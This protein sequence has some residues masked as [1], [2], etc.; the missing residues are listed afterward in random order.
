ML[1]LASALLWLLPAA[2]FA[3][4]NPATIIELYVTESDYSTPVAGVTVTYTTPSLSGQSFTGV[5]DGA[6][7]VR[8]DRGGFPFP[9]ETGTLA[10]PAFGGFPGK[11]EDVF[12]DGNSTYPDSVDWVFSYLLA[13]DEPSSDLT[14]TILNGQGAPIP[15]VQVDISGQTSAHI[16]FGYTNAAGKI[17]FSGLEDEDFEVTVN[18]D[19]FAE[20]L[21]A[22]PTQTYVV[23]VYTA[24][25][26]GAV[27]E[28]LTLGS[29]TYQLEVKVVK[30]NSDGTLSTTPVPDVDV[31]AWELIPPEGSSGSEFP[32]WGYGKT[33]S[34]GL[35][36]M[37]MKEFTSNKI[38]I[39]VYKDGYS[40][41]NKE[42]RLSTTGTKTTVVIGIRQTDSTINYTLKKGSATGQTYVVPDNKYADVGCNT[43]DYQSGASSYYYYSPV[44]PGYSSGSISVT[45]GY[46]YE[47]RAWIEGVGYS[48]V[49]TFVNSGQT[50]NLTF[51]IHIP[52]AKLTVEFRD[53]VTGELVTGVPIDLSLWTDR[54]DAE[55]RG[56]TFIEH[57]VWDQVDVG[58]KTF[59]VIAGQRYF[60]YAHLGS[61]FPADQNPRVVLGD[62]GKEYIIPFNIDPIDIKTGSN[63]K[64][65]I[66]L[67]SADA[68]IRVK[69]LDQNGNPVKPSDEFDPT[70]S[71]W[72]NAFSPGLLGEESE[73]PKETEVPIVPAESFPSEFWTDASFND[74]AALFNRPEH[75]TKITTDATNVE[76]ISNASIQ[77]TGSTGQFGYLASYDSSYGRGQKTGGDYLRVHDFDLATQYQIDVDNR[78]LLRTAY[79]RFEDEQIE[80]GYS[81]DDFEVSVGSHHKLSPSSTVLTRFEVF[82]RS[83]D[84]FENGIIENI[85]QA[86]VF[87]SERFP[88]DP[89]TLIL[90]QRTDEDS[91]N[92]RGNVQYILD[93]EYFDIV[94][95]AQYLS[96][97]EDAHEKSN[98]IK[99]IPD[100]TSD[101]PYAR[102]TSANPSLDSYSTYLYTTIDPDP[103]F[104]FQ[105]GLSYTGIELPAYDV[106]A[107]FADGKRSD[108]K[109][110]PKIGLSLYPTEDT[111]VR[112]AYFQTLGVSTVSDIGTLEPTLVGSFNQVYGDLPGGS[113]ENFGVGIDHKIPG[114]F[115]AGAEYVY[116]D[117]ARDG[118]YISESETL[119]FDSLLETSKTSIDIVGE[120]EREH[121]IRTYLYGVLS[122]SYTA[123]L[124]YLRDDLRSVDLEQDN[125]TDRIAAQINYFSPQRWFAFG[126]TSWYNQQLEN[127]AVFDD[128]SEDFWIL[129]VGTGYRIP[130]RHGM[131]QLALVNVLDQSFRYSDRDRFVAPPQGIGFLLQGS[132][133]F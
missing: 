105:L 66:E 21:P 9:E 121:L 37:G 58:T 123:T 89:A 25:A 114:K 79:T 129:D 125:V 93:Q 72:V 120:V 34:E 28:S 45:G 49:K 94:A 78:V 130:E 81:R 75:R 10:I 107:P 98:G 53:E 88:L 17:T 11:T 127:D 96:A 43:T 124:D 91:F 32:F 16:D 15:G 77:Q 67:Q 131:V 126:R 26:G 65:S 70:H 23:S 30:K 48:E 104:D 54:Y 69:L 82:D 122:K 113:T 80:D 3:Q 31:S 51:I 33:G 55:S 41:G 60:T 74:Y 40:E 52:N 35:L 8:I 6:G 133:N 106:I 118:I 119:N 57:S 95:G 2:L 116:R 14:L 39:Y 103:F 44:E 110:S 132:F 101:F 85:D 56:A 111:T 38:G 73:F 117:I 62:N 128:G 86:Y 76:D 83:V 19:G 108:E 61:D 5:T 50:K 92:L 27:S 22:Y 87:M 112:A 13:Y 63:N 100:L 42:I 7:F 97:E 99:E 47:C 20:Y 115:Y 1:V 18:Q 29:W 24:G 71:G 90:D 64:L 12:L 102:M 109:L 4:N 36:M 84:T 68:L 46:E 59:D